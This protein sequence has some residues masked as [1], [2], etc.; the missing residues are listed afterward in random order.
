MQGK[1]Y[2]ATSIIASR[3]RLHARTCR[4]YKCR[5]IRLDAEFSNIPVRLFFIQYGK[6]GEWTVLL[7]TDR[8]LNFKKAFE[9]YQ[10]R[11]NVEVMYREC[12][13]YLRLGK[14]QSNDFDAQIADAT[15]AFMAYTMISLKKRMCEYETFGELFRTL[16]QECLAMT[17]WHRVLRQFIQV[18]QKI[19]QHNSCQQAKPQEAQAGIWR[20]SL[21]DFL[22]QYILDIEEIAYGKT[23]F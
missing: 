16:Q 13:Q 4:E 6:K 5:Y 8:T 18:L 20:G 7:T 9:Y 10:I 12:K 14:C 3:E 22:K 1:K 2:N 11:W 15:L 19:S 17:L 23:S 21:E